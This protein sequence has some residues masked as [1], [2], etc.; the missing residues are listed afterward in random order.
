MIGETAQVV[1][2][3]RHKEARKR[4]DK[5][6]PDR[7][8]L[9]AADALQKRRDLSRIGKQGA[10]PLTQQNA[11]H[12]E[13]ERPHVAIEQTCFDALFKLVDGLRDGRLGKPERSRRRRH[14]PAVA[15][16]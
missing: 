11:A 16:V 1:W 7:R 12:R 4:I 14:R 2:Q 15:N 6:D 5:A 3:I 10:C 13:T 9:A 8:E